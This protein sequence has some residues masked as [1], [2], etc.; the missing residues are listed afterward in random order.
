M[1][2]ICQT[3]FVIFSVFF[4]F[5]V[6]INIKIDAQE[7]YPFEGS[8]IA[9]ALIIHSDTTK[10]IEVTQL[11]YGTRVSVLEKV[12][13]L[14][15]IKYDGN[16][17]GYASA[18]YIVN[19]GANTLTT[20]Q[21]GTETYRAY[22]DSLIQNGFIESY[23]PYLYYLHVKHPNWTFKADVNKQSLETYAAKE[24][25]KVV[26]QTANQNYWL[27]SSPIEGS[28]YYVNQSV[29]SSYLD[30]RN[31]LYESRIFQFLDLEET[32]DIY[33]DASLKAIAGTGN[34]SKYISTFEQ[35][36]NTHQI[37]ALHIMSRSKQEGANNSTYSAV[38]GTYSTTSG[39]LS[40]QGYSLDG[41]YNFYNIGSYAYA[42]YQY[43]VQRGLAYA[44]GYLEND[45]CITLNP[46]TGKYVY[47]SAC[48]VLSFQ[49][50]WDTP[51]KAI[52][53]GAEFIAADYVR[54]GQDTN[55]Y[56]KF[57]IS[58][59][60]KYELTGHQY[61][62]NLYA[63]AGEAD[64]IYRAYS[65]GGLFAY[66]E[67]TKNYNFVFVIPVYQNMKTTNYQ[68]RDR[69][70]DS[71]LSSITINGEEISGFDSDVIEYNINAVTTEDTIQIGATSRDVGA[72]I[73]G[74]GKA[75]FSNG[76]LN[77]DVKV[78]AEDSIH[79]TTYHLHIKKV[80]P[81]ANITI[82]SILGKMNVKVR[83]NYMY[84]ISPNIVAST[85]I[86]TVTKNGGSAIVTDSKGKN[87]TG[88]LATGDK[89]T[90][91]GTKETKT[92]T[93]A[94]RGDLSG[95]GV[96][97]IND[98]I[99]IQSHILGSRTLTGEMLLSADINYD[100]VVKIND[101]ILVQSAILGKANL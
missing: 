83:D 70:T 1:K 15:K 95:D 76:E 85:L 35:A 88:S 79:V 62:T 46:N 22:C 48:G 43:T 8:I 34:L 89:I 72:L 98:L 41:Y 7:V 101:L 47:N 99:L 73:T 31:S 52:S 2:K 36:A 16:K 77:V 57:N 55:Y 20:D 81:N 10:K 90:I 96:V 58:S 21:A 25:W 63:P 11:V 80:S 75:T 56:Q 33:N 65:A 97:K 12:N 40:H 44:A 59:Y 91:K 67:Q 61:M 42:P 37:N 23:C 45:S 82:D 39:R 68:A 92:F 9:D 74:L 78:V 30:P 71:K 13:N 53:G 50:P 28:Y 19:V 94:V 18:N 84:G 14:Y 26:L 4:T 87:K 66:N 86:N 49:R 24:E 93:I 51:E 5:I 32:K 64:I 38:A 60:T 100:G 27:S 3:F 69:S 6:G 29:I 17:I 54:K